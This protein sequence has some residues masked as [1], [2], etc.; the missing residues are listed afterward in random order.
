MG[1]DRVQRRL[2]A[3]LA[4]D[5]VGY[6][7][8]MEA[9][10]QGTLA[11]LKAVRRDVFQ[12]AM[13]KHRGRTFKTTG[14]GALVE[15]TSVINAVTSAIEVQT[16]MAT[17]NAE[18]AEGERIV[19]RIGVSLGDVMVEGGDLYGNGVNV[20]ARMQTLARARRDLRLRQRLRACP[21]HARRGVR[22]PR[23][24]DGQEP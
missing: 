15:F 17:R 11:R 4:A 20:A 2:V 13:L 14:D 24:A 23:R 7:R 5:V 1:E 3:I 9:D 21:R 10:E 8:L 12:P 6:S 18:A 22:G 16:A 19:L